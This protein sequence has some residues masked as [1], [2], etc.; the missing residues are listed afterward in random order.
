MPDAPRTPT[1]H[2]EVPR[3]PTPRVA[4]DGQRIPRSRQA[5]FEKAVKGLQKRLKDADS[6]FYAGATGFGPAG[7][8]EATF[9]AFVEAHAM[10]SRAHR[11]MLVADSYP[12]QVAMMLGVGSAGE[13]RQGTRRDSHRGAAERL[14]GVTR[15]LT[16]APLA[17]SEPGFRRCR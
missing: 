11:Y 7:G 17:E 6:N 2:V 9:R 14:D 10:H 3:A 13:G 16:N 1:P 4:R 12:K 15:A 5:S 8:F